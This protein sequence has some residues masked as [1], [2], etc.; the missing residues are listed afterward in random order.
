MKSILFTDEMVRSTLS[1]LKTQ[2]RRPLKPQPDDDAKIMIGEMGSSKGVAYIGNSMSG[3]HVTRIVSPYGQVGDRLWVRETFCLEHQVEGDQPPPFNDGR[4]ILYLRDGIECAKEDAEIWIQP[5]YRAT[6]P[7]PELSYYG[8]EEEPTVRW[9]SSIHMPRWAS[10][11]TLEITEIRVER[12]QEITEKEAKAEG[13]LPCPH[14]LSKDDE[15][16]DCYLDAGEYTCSF[17]HLWDHLYAKNGLGVDA[18]PWVWVIGFRRVG[19]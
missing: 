1:G 10:R 3:G 8:S 14:P 15:C 7:T 12:V 18:N 4:P 16:L 11:I 6:D 9:K 2:T 5:H 19:G 13:V 17:L